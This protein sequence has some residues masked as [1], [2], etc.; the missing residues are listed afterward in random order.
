MWVGRDFIVDT[1]GGG[2]LEWKAIAAARQMLE[3]GEPCCRIERYPLGPGLGQCCG[4]VV[5]LMIECLTSGDAHWCARIASVMAEGGSIQRVVTLQQGAGHGSEEPAAAAP[6]LPREPLTVDMPDRVLQDVGKQAFT[7]V[8]CPDSENIVIADVWHA[9]HDHIVVCGSGHIGKAIV[10]L[11]ADL[12]VRVTWLDPREGCW[13][14]DIPSNVQV[15]QG[16]ESDVPDMPDHAYWL[17]LTHNHALDL[18]IID[19]VLRY[20]S[21][22]FLGLIGSRSKKARFVSRLSRRHRPELVDRICCPIGAVQTAS[23]LPA[24]IAVSV[25]A[26]LLEQ[27]DA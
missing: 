18:A 27:M 9:P 17:V 12:P 2:H 19:A 3:E 15:V 24:V 20:R 21:F 14:A 7:R 11:L 22:A 5:W 1:I 26:Q 23:K 13:P 8:T 10:R 4:G 25:V 16:D 6:G